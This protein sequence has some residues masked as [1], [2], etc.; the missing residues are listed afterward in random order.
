MR[1]YL[2]FAVIAVIL[3]GFSLVF[4]ASEISSLQS[5]EKQEVQKE[6]VVENA[7]EP[8]IESPVSESM[9]GEEINW[10]VISSGGDIGGT[11]TNFILSGTV[12]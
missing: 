1:K 6:L 2:L 3:G 5:G 4:A 11:S 10:Y 7:T 9:T 8:I 12:G